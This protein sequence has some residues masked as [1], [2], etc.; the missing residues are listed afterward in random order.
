[1]AQLDDPAMYHRHVPNNWLYDIWY[2]S[3]DLATSER[4]DEVIQDP[5]TPGMLPPP[6][7]LR[8]LWKTS[9]LET[10]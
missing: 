4:L 9:K 5:F 8:D 6:G 1:M 3:D 2:S 10:S 7:M